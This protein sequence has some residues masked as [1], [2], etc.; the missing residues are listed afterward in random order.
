[1]HRHSAGLVAHI[2]ITRELNAFVHRDGQI[3]ASGDADS[4]PGF[5][6]R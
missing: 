2:G 5:P 4:P 1:M 3:K 6:R